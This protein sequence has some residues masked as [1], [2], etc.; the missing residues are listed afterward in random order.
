VT[1]IVTFP[2]SDSSHRRA[3]DGGGKLLEPAGSPGA[4]QI[5]I[6]RRGSRRLDSEELFKT[7]RPR[8]LAIAYGMLGSASDAEDVVQEAFLRWQ[9]GGAGG[10]DFPERYLARIVTRL[11]IDHL[12]AVKRRRED[13]VGVWLPEPV[14]GDGTDPE[15]M[16][17]L[18]D[19][20][21]FALLR[22]LETLTPVERAVF[23]LCEVFGYRHA[24]V[25]RMIGKTEANTRQILHRARTRVIAER[26]SRPVSRGETE[27]LVSAFLEA[28]ARGDMAALLAIL[29]EDIVWY[30]DGGGKAP[31]VLQPVRGA[32]KAARFAVGLA[33][34]FSADTQVRV[35]NVN[36]QPAVLV[37][38]QGALAGVLIPSV[39]NG[40]I[41]ELDWV[42]NPDKLRLVRPRLH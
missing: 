8:L 13:Y 11:S 36:G 1:S 33:R 29:D 9:R 17:L 38:L 15:G 19:S 37:Y 30:G 34:Q 12:R 40:R 6:A 25:G 22:V 42:S 35:A 7:Q 23:L 20:L 10:V 2:V 18:A 31:A 5:V 4:P 27:R 16:T 39:A 26:P 32:A 28:A 21:S 24:E 14:T 3:V 41:R